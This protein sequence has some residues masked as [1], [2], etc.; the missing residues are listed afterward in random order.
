[1]KTNVDFLDS[2]MQKQYNADIMCKYFIIIYGQQ[3]NDS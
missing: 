2:V 1:M 3:W